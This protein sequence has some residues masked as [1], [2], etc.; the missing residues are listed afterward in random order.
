VKGQ[1]P[2]ESYFTPTAYRRTAILCVSVGQGYLPEVMEAKRKR[3]RNRA[4]IEEEL[5]H[6]G[7]IVS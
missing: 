7:V 2:R 3:E 5:R 1:Q 6:N 4:M